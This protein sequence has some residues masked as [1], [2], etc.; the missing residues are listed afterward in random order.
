MIVV[1]KVPCRR[2]STSSLGGSGKRR[3][4]LGRNGRRG[5]RDPRRGRLFQNVTGTR[6]QF[7]PYRGTGPALGSGGQSDRFYRRPGFNSLQHVRDGKIRAY[8][9][10][11]S[12]PALGARH[13]DR[14]GA[15]L[16]SL[17][18]S[19]WYS[20]WAPK[21]TPKEIIAKLNAAAVQAT[22]RRAATLRRARPRRAAPRPADAR[23]ARRISKGRDREVVA[24]DQGRQYQDRI[25]KP[26]KHARFE[27]GV[28][29]IGAGK[30]RS[31]DPRPRHSRRPFPQSCRQRV[32]VLWRA[33][34][35]KHAE[36]VG[37]PNGVSTPKRSFASASSAASQPPCVCALREMRA[38][39]S[40]TRCGRARC[41]RFPVLR[42]PSW[43][44]RAT[45]LACERRITPSSIT[46]SPLAAS[47]VPSS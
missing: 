8:A 23:S 25:A 37:P 2:T 26:A 22:S 30:R 24:G 20:L 10:T 6:F 45:R 18:I 3:Q 17:D 28:E 42:H 47:V 46:L 32:D 19:V 21:G 27:L 43:R 7:V 29:R 36:E 5:L 9:V 4:S 13:S 11:A 16:P 31:Q 14:C 1:S 39:A 40:A 41:A 33:V 38:R 15:G 34:Q 12:A 35:R 44:A